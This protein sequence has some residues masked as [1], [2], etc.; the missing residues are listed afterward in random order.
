MAAGGSAACSGWGSCRLIISARTVLADQLLRAW[1]EARG[2][3][4][5]GKYLKIGEGLPAT[6][7]AIAAIGR[8]RLPPTRL[9]ECGRCGPP[10]VGRRDRS[11]TQLEGFFAS[12]AGMTDEISQSIL[13]LPDNQATRLP[14]RASCLQ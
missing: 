12:A 2:A 13:D 5:K 6:L 10:G 4:R 7:A 1:I 14:W 8:S 9:N 3:R 11:L